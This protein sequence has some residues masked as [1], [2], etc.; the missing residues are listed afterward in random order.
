LAAIGEAFR[1]GGESSGFG[2]EIETSSVWVFLRRLGAPGVL[3][4]EGDADFEFIVVSG[5]VNEVEALC[6]L[7]LLAPSAGDGSEHP[8][9]K[10]PR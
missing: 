9:S 6:V 8:F 5:K 7:L 3:V 10:A 1:A 4:D 2:R